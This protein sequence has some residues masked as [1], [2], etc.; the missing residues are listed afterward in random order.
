[1]PTRTTFSSARRAHPSESLSRLV[2]GILHVYTYTTYM[3]ARKLHSAAITHWIIAHW[4]LCLLQSTDGQDFEVY[5]GNKD[6]VRPVREY[7]T[8][9]CVDG[10]YLRQA[11]IDIPADANGGGQHNISVRAYGA[12]SCSYTISAFSP[13]APAS[14]AA[15]VAMVGDGLD[16]DRAQKAW[17]G[18][19]SAC[20]SA[21]TPHIPPSSQSCGRTQA[22]VR[23]NPS[24]VSPSVQTAASRLGCSLQSSSSRLPAADRYFCFPLNGKR[25]RKPALPCTRPFASATT[26]GA[27][28]A[29]K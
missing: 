25:S 3:H 16:V 15:P 19:G 29:T 1:M 27:P 5:Y 11:A 28:S 6:I 14:A 13:A 21:P 2:F 26:C 23:L 9:T 8:R 20:A 18:G 17:L 24:L 12:P 7:H 10:E 22:P 4:T